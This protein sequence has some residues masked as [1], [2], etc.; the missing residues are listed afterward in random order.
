MDSSFW[1]GKG[2]IFKEFSSCSTKKKDLCSFIWSSRN[3]FLKAD[4]LVSSDSLTVQVQ[5]RQ[6]LRYNN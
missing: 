5:G 6:K 3:T 4:D 1:Q 2:T